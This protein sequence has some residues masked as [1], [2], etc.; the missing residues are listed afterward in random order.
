MPAH[1]L[2]LYFPE[3]RVSWDGD[4]MS[5]EGSR[6]VTYFPPGP[7]FH[8]AVDQSGC[9]IITSFPFQAT[10]VSFHLP[11]LLNSVHAFYW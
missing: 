11:C 9:V 8:L 10:N 5:A 1:S 6:T 7:P 4:P 2:D 3:P